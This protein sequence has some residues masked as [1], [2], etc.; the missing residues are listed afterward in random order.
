MLYNRFKNSLSEANTASYAVFEKQVSPIPKDAEGFVINYF[1]IIFSHFSFFAYKW[2]SFK[3]RKCVMLINVL[4]LLLL[5]NTGIAAH[6]ER[7]ATI[8]HGGN[9][10][11]IFGRV[12]QG[13][14]FLSA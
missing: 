14:L 1:V 2:K 3:P 11:L 6:R 4:L 8:D 5:F 9:A 7:H 13:R 10:I 12:L